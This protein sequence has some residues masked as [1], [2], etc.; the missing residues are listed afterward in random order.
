MSE[1]KLVEEIVTRS[2]SSNWDAAKLEWK[3]HEIYESE[4]RE[5]C[6][7]GH[8]PIKEICVIENQR[9]A[10]QVNVGNCCVKKFMGLPS[11]KIFQAIKRVRVDA[12]RSINAETIEYAR[13]RG[14]I[15][16]WEQDFYLSIMRKRKLTPKMRSKKIQIN[17]KLVSNMKRRQ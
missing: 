14:W 4:D 12:E 3:L 16:G 15:N 7:C 17:K 5:R 11:D 6:L 1:Y 8:Y 10:K 2:I 9:N 13:K